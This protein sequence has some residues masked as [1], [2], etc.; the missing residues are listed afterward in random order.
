[1][2]ATGIYKVALYIT[3][4]GRVLRSYCRDDDLASMD[5]CSLIGVYDEEATE[6]D[7]VDDVLEMADG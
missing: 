7:I 3:P 4:D 6:S 1:M 5:V 2:I